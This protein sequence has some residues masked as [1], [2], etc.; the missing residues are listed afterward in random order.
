MSVSLRRTTRS[1]DETRDLG[2]ALAGLL[3]PG[4]VV[5]LAGELGA[6]KTV[7]AQGIA[8]GLGID[9]REV[10]SPTFVLASEHAGRL[11]MVHLDLY[12]IEDPRE[13]DDVGV[14]ELLGGDGVAVV[15][16]AD[17]FPA[18]LGEP[19]IVVRLAPGATPDERAVEIEWRAS[20]APDGWRERL[21]AATA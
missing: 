10:A 19:V 11:R 16:W 12:R 17:R 21:A 6:G 7:F 1:A 20:P 3:G 14:S 8:A 9:P 4:D 2:R 15:E 13:L 5:F 18:E